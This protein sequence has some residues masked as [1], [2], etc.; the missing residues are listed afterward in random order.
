M[1][2]LYSVDVR[3]FATAYIRAESVE[4]AKAKALE[5]LDG[6]QI[7]LATGDE[8]AVPVSG[9]RYDSPDLPEVSLSPVATLACLAYSHS[10]LLCGEPELVEGVEPDAEEA[11][12]RAGCERC[13][14]MDHLKD[15]DGEDLCTDCQHAAQDGSLYGESDDADASTWTGPTDSDGQPCKFLN[16]YTCPCGEEWTDQWSSQCDDRC[17]ACN[18][19]TSPHTSEEVEQ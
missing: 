16:H 17:P 2:K 14:T 10:P 9:E 19:A 3:V 15:V 12:D 8:Q 5:G 11:N 4:E 13:G 6:Q 1:S 7:Y 18:T